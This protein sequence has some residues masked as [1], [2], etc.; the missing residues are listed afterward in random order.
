[1]LLFVWPVV[2]PVFYG[3]LVIPSIYIAKRHGKPGML[4][5]WSL[6]VF[7]LLHA[8]GG[9][10]FQCGARHGSAV[11]NCSVG[12]LLVASTGLW[13]EAKRYLESLTMIGKITVGII[14][15]LILAGSFLLFTGYL[16]LPISGKMRLYIACACLGVACFT[17]L[18]QQVWSMK[19]EK[20][21][22]A[23]PPH[24]VNVHGTFEHKR[25]ADFF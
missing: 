4:G 10:M 13:F 8:I 18:A 7:C 24:K 6:T 17:A 15:F 19:G 2:E 20:F 5:W 21:S 25:N 1:M 16:A 9:V 11:L 22:I 14:C 23:T 12:M 3:M